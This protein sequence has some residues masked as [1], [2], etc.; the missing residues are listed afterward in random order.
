MQ[1]TVNGV[2]APQ[3]LL[4]LTFAKPSLFLNLAQTYSS[5][6]SLGFVAVALNADGSVNS[7]TNP[8]APGSALSVFVNGLTPDPQITTA[9]LLLFTNDGWSVTNTA[10]STPFVLRVDLRVPSQLVN[11]FSCPNPL[12]PCTASLTLFDVY[13]GS[14]G[15]S[16]SSSSLAF[17]GV[18]YVNRTQ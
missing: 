4:Q 11:N 10:Q 18:V 16:V 6:N 8:A 2:T 17:G 1:L 15:Q 7:P 14:V 5:T 3:R 13:G 9:P 12:S